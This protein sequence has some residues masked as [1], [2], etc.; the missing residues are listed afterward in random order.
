M[1]QREKWQGFDIH[2]DTET[3]TDTQMLFF[4]DLV[5]PFWVWVWVLTLSRYNE[6]LLLEQNCSI[7]LPGIGL[8]AVLENFL[9]RPYSLTFPGLI[10]LEDFRNLKFIT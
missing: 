3:Q 5:S 7:S 9:N 10:F 4:P 8:P 6:V 1:V 2:T